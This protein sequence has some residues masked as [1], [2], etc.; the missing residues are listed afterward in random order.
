MSHSPPAA[1]SPSPWRRPMFARPADEQHRTATMLELFFDLCFVTAVAQAA[2]AF[3]H[4]LAQGR[5]GHG[6]LGYAMVFF[7]IWWAWMNFTW[8][9]SAYDTDD[10][11][12]RLLTLVQ[13]VGALVLAAGASEALQ[14]EDFTVITWGYVIMRLAMVTQWLRAARSDPERRRTCLRYAVGI[15]V[16]QVGWVVRL[17]LPDDIGVATFAVLVVAEIAVPVVAE[18]SATTSWHPHHIAERYG[19]FT[20]IVLGESITAATGAVHAALDSDAALGDLA[21]LVIG[22]I[23]TVFA[24]W[25]LYFAK[26]V[27]HR[28]TSLRA[29]LLW[30]YG[31]YLVFASAA[32]VGAGLAVNVALATGHGHLSDRAA[33]ATYTVPVALFVA[34]V[35]LLHHYAG[36][37][38][39]GADALHPL[40]VVAVL[41]ATFAPSPILVTGI[42]TALLIAAT[43]VLATRNAAQTASPEGDARG[44]AQTPGS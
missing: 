3:E 6:V 5:I 26:S 28:L 15:F 22:G 39:R 31:H 37:L 40:A 25:W 41:A 10:V 7:A 27:H 18:R 30:G 36:G 17:A 24:L 14:H 32:A 20:L 12:Y 2:S 19:L 42:L 34:L 21:T 4:E 29:A 16:V 9:A 38:P 44:A 1:P 13:I 23:L 11:P 35:W 43:L 8:F 33:A